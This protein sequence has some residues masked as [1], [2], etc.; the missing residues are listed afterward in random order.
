M[1]DETTSEVREGQR[2]A[3]VMARAGL[4][5]RRDAEAWI[6]A[7]RVTVNGKVLD[8]PAYNVSETDDVRVDGERLAQ[9]E[10]TRLF[11]FHKGRGL[12]TTARDPEGRP[13]IFD[14]LPPDLPR[15]VA[16]GRL[17]IN[18]EGLLLLTNDGGLARVLELPATGW[19]RRY[20]VRAHGRV[21]QAK[22]D[23]LSGGVTVDG[24]DYAG[25][26]ARLD[27]EQGSNVWITMGL[28][29]GKNREIKKVLVHLGLSVNRLIRVSFGPFE[30][31]DLEEGEVAEV[32]TRVLRD[33][34]GAKLAR[35]AGVDFDAPI[36]ERAA[37]EV[38]ASE[39]ER[40]S[41][42]DRRDSPGRERT[43]TGRDRGGE[44]LRRG[45]TEAAARRGPPA[46]SQPERRRKHVSALR[47]EIAADAA[48]PRKRIERGATHD[49]K[50]RT[51]AVERISPAGEEAR[52]RA[53]AE[54]RAPR[55]AGRPSVG[56]RR[57]Q[58]F[59]PKRETAERPRRPGPSEVK[60]ARDGEGRERPPRA[61]HKGHAP[62][63][64]FKRQGPGKETRDGRRA[65]R[66][67]DRPN[68]ERAKRS[69]AAAP[70]AERA[71][72]AT[73]GRRPPRDAAAR[74]RKFDR[75]QDERRGKAN[76][77]PSSRGGP[78]RPGK[79]PSK[80]PGGG[81]RRPPRKP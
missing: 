21:D 56:K 29:E 71:R 5:S 76:G 9:R 44:F 20:R 68:A 51:V 19:L 73:A 43:G 14:A 16:V 54:T 77:G 62:R 72:P 33:Q 34:L 4:C 18:T 50:G 36:A 6:A 74:D 15:L 60:R 23:S 55:A 8:S 42:S 79:S 7:G 37:A 45:A 66:D 75:P 53:A 69:G 49:R 30:L 26:E 58:S 31:G 64:E 61:E 70:R 40:R 41:K 38:A 63:A 57:A 27:R 78:G 59:E 81:S 11:L 12:V 47:A 25:I 1:S 46:P 3:K 17:D 13:T 48:G 2:I 80:G 28:R 52:K 67:G 22:L 24:V 32:R 35:E 10:R 39:E 65:G